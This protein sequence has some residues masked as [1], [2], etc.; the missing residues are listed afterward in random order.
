MSTKL[1]YVF[2]IKHSSVQRHIYY[3]CPRVDDENHTVHASSSRY[4]VWTRFPTAANDIF[5]DN[6]C[7]ATCDNTAVLEQHEDGNKMFLMYFYLFLFLVGE[8]NI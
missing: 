5:P 3:T 4:G 8:Q 1:Y 2:L 7:F 6:N